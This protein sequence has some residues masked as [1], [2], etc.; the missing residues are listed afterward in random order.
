MAQGK[1]FSIDLQKLTGISTDNLLS[2]KEIVRDHQTQKCDN[3]LLAQL[4]EQI[5]F[6]VM[7]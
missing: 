4:R 2:I 7:L 5:L 1:E 3:S 6:E